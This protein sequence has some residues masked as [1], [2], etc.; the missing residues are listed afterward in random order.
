MHAMNP[1]VMFRV[2]LLL[3]CLGAAVQAQAM[4]SQN[5]LFLSESVPP[6]LIFT[7]DDSGS[8]RWAFGPD[9]VGRENSASNIRGTRR[10]MSSTSNPMYYNPNVTYRLPVRLDANGTLAATGYDTSFTQ[11]WHTGYHTDR[12]S[13]NLSNNYKV[14]WNFNTDETSN[15]N[16]SSNTNYGASTGQVYNL[17]PNPAADF[18]PTFTLSL[19]NNQS[20]TVKPYPQ[21]GD[22]TIKRTGNSTCTA[23]SSD[24]ASISCSRNNSTST[25][26][27]DLTQ[28]GV[29]AYYYVYDSTSKANCTPADNDCYRLR[30]VTSTSGVK[31]TDE[32]KNFAIW[33]SFYRTRALA[34]Q[35]A[36]NLAFNELAS[37]VRLTW[38]TL[39]SCTTLNSTNTTGACANNRF[40]EYSP[41][42]KANFLT[43]L[44]NQKFEKSTHLLAATARAGEFLKTDVAW[45]RNPNPLNANGTT[46]TTVT[47]PV[48]A[49][50][51]S[52]HVLMTDGMWNDGTA[53][54][55]THRDDSTFTVG[56]YAYNGKMAPF[57]DTTNVT[58][59]DVA[60]HYWATDLRP[61]LSNEVRPY[62]R[63]PN[64]DPAKQFWDPRNNPATWQHM[65]NYT[66]GLALTNSL[67]APGIPWAGE[68]FKGAGYEALASGAKKWPAA[69]SSSDNNVYDLWHAAIN[70]RGEFFSV[71]SPQDMVDAFQTILTRI[72]DRE[73]S[74]AA[75]SMESAVT[76]SGNEAY[77]ARFSSETWSGELIKYAVDSNGQLS[78]Q[79]NARDKLNGKSAGSRNILF[80]RNGTLDSFIW[81]NLSAEQQAL[82]GRTISGTADNLGPDRVDF[83]RGDR[84]NEE[85][86]FRKR[87][88]V[89]GD[90]VHS[91]P[92][93]VSAPDRMESMMNPLNGAANS[94]TE[95]KQEHKNRAKRIYVGAN[96]GM[97][98]GFDEEGEEVFA[99][100]PTEVIG[101]LHKLTDKSYN[102]SHQYFVDGTPVV[103]DV[104]FEGAWHTVLIGSLRGG[105][106]SI[107]ALDVT[108]PDNVSLLWEFGAADDEDMGFSFTTPVITRAGN[109]KWVV[110]LSN[111]YYSDSGKA[112]LYMLNVE[113]GEVLSKLEV[114][115]D[116]N[117]VNGLSSP[118]T[119]D[120]NGDLI[121]DYVYAG[122]LQGNVW[123][124][125]LFN[126]SQGF[127]T[128]DSALA[129][130]TFRVGF[131]GNP[132]YVATNSSGRQPITV[133]P[134]LV[135]HIS[136]RGYV[137][138]FGTGRYIENSDAQADTS[139][140]MTLYGIWDR[141][142]DGNAAPSTP[143]L[144]RTRLQQQTL[145]AE[146]SNT[147]AD[148]SSAGKA[149]DLRLLSNNNVDWVSDSNTNGKY[150]WY[151]DLTTGGNRKGEMI[152]TP[153][154]SRAN[155][156]LVTT[157]TPND[158]PCAAGMERWF[159]ALNAYTGGRTDFNVLDMSGN[160]Y[161][162]AYDSYNGQVVSS[163]KIPGFGSP[164]VVGSKGYFNTETGIADLQMSFGPA[165]SN[166]QS[167]RVVQ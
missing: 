24:F 148:P 145:G 19:S 43:W 80:N 157:T 58:L 51:P 123:R 78:Y 74:A 140:A 118:Q 83:I 150:G 132:L 71:D 10:G 96:D 32:R 128:K 72:A 129:D 102:A 137:V 85:T 28:T 57:A 111:G 114:E 42:H 87:T 119:V 100:I 91:S 110:L 16:Y 162:D 69:S 5:P 136:G 151:L 166:R 156:L 68:T 40:R 20:T 101:N 37:S 89:L 53:P 2:S 106:R 13:L 142:T 143:S 33:Y 159:I 146:L 49:C 92:V 66:M 46:G 86:L 125:D 99:F 138:T 116:E 41:R 70:S 120:V 103:G 73:T 25:F 63:S 95:F 113:D 11:A 90:I 14:S 109:G 39:G 127:A 124:F 8:M 75:V 29:P 4:P 154:M 79:W 121:V 45:A 31:S 65:V 76:S 115:G 7:L 52:Y 67:N 147:F 82:I 6:N 163:V 36:A 107:F 64:S 35:T 3:A 135:R 77:Y 139:Q 88:H 59:A 62:I 27:L 93:V 131:S 152:V 56:G 155:V 130:S 84:S 17:S 30:F 54:S 161:V 165:A 122:D 18:K 98:H 21:L 94:Y 38:Q 22:I 134:T 117:T 149:R 34:T 26:T 48:Y 44:A 108:N 47:N 133:A 167:W 15:Y 50:R 144:S 158:N 12:G 23:T 141:Q 81:N 126:A 112:V 105:G 1:P 104:Y 164:A 55:I 9:E 160:N 60:M 61:T 153:M 97:L